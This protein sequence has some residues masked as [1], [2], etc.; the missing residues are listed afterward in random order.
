MASRSAVTLTETAF[1]V[2]ADQIET[3][4]IDVTSVA[5]VSFAA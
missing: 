3:G 1:R 4:E 2:L 5:H